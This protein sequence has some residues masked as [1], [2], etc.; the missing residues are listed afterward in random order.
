[1]LCPNMCVCV[2]IRMYVCVCVIMCVQINGLTAVF[3]FYFYNICVK[4]NSNEYRCFNSFFYMLPSIKK[5]ILECSFFKEKLPLKEQPL[6]SGRSSYHVFHITS[7]YKIY[8]NNILQK[9]QLFC[10]IWMQ[11]HLVLIKMK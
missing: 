8:N 11:L 2:C 6:R 4:S 7:F 3:G 1:M 5:T 9:F 10:V